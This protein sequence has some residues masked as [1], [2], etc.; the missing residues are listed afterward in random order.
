MKFSSEVNWTSFD[1]LIA[2]I[3]LTLLVVGIELVLRIF[4]TRRSRIIAFFVVLSVFLLIWIELA[5][6][7]INSPLAGN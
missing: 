4:S 7:I 6:G 1:F 3:L 2:A 5:V